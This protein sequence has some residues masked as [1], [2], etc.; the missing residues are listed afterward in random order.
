MGLQ[1][2]REQGAD[3][4]DEQNPGQ[5]QGPG[6]DDMAEDSDQQTEHQDDDERVQLG[7]LAGDEQDHG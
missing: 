3:Q 1:H 2:K 7:L 4:P 6:F 5:D